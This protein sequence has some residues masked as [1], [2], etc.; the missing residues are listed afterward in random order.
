VAQY[1]TL[2]QIDLAAVARLYGLNNPRL[3]PLA[4]GAANSSFRLSSESGEYVLTILDNHD[5][6]SAERLAAHT[7]ALYDLGVPTTTVVPASDGASITHLDGRPVMLKRWTEGEVKQPLP[8]V[9]LPEAGRI[10]AKLHALSPQAPGLTDVPV[11]RRRLST[12]QESLIRDFPDTVFAAWL[13]EQLDRIRVAEAKNK[14]PRT[15][16]H[17][18]LFD[19]NIVVRPDESLT[20]LDWETISL[21][22]PLLDLGMAAV[23]LAQEGGT[24]SPDR[25]RALVAGYEQIA[26]LPGEDLADLPTEIAHAAVIIAFHRYYRHNVRFP[27]ASKAGYH[28]GMVKFVDSVAGLTESIR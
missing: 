16:V 1:T 24:L 6:A 27:D 11:C 28:M 12:E 19:D 5:T 7:Q 10:L 13:T 20:V 25:L 2:E 26:P 18:D 22:D 8:A 4:G 3:A 14:R 15:L 17:G 21:D 23:G 9:L